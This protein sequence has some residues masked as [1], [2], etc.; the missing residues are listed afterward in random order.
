MADV[1]AD[2]ITREWAM[3]YLDE[4]ETLLTF[5]AKLPGSLDEPQRAGFEWALRLI[6]RAHESVDEMEPCMVPGVKR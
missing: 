2:P 6:R 3:R 4:A 1:H 5:W